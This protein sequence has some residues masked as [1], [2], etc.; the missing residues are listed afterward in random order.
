MMYNPYIVIA[1]KKEPE[2]LNIKESKMQDKFKFRAVLETDRFAII[3]PVETVFE[4]GYQID[5]NI[6]KGTRRPSKEIADE[7]FE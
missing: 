6:A 7:V 4:T 5:T 1:T 2:R 3:V